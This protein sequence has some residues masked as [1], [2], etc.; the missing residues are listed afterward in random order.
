[1]R[2]RD[3]LGDLAEASIVLASIGE[4]A[5][6]YGDFVRLASPRANQTCARTKF[7]R[8]RGSWIA[9]FADTAGG[10]FEK[11]FSDRPRQAAIRAL[12][13]GVREK[14]RNELAF[15]A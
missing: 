15:G 10:M 6:D 2:A 9:G 14:P 8:R 11:L 7:G 5:F 3:G 12:L 1:V 13:Q 4:A